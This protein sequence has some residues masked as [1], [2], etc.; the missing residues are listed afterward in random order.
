MRLVR[1]LRASSAV[2]QLF[3]CVIC[4]ALL[5]VGM[6]CTRKTPPSDPLHADV[7]VLFPDGYPPDPGA[8]GK[9]GLEGVDSDG[10]GVR[11]DVQRWIYARHSKDPHKRAALSQVAKSYTDLIQPKDRQESM[12]AAMR[13]YS[14]AIDCLS[15]VIP[16]M[17]ARNIER[18]YLKARVLNTEERSR[19]FLNNDALLD[20]T[21]SGPSSKRGAASCD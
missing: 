20:G 19:A 8:K 6:A 3:S 17:Q 12:L 4:L 14:K 11:D 18:S 13:S 16:E 15:S 10:D 21:T 9:V 2:S 5:S 7:G 1:Y